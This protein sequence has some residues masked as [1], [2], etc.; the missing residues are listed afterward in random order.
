MRAKFRHI[1]TSKQRPPV[2]G[3]LLISLIRRRVLNQIWKNCVSRARHSTTCY[4]LVASPGSSMRY[5]QSTGFSI[6][7]T[8][9][10]PEAMPISANNRLSIRQFSLSRLT[11]SRIRSAK[12]WVRSIIFQTGL[13]SLKTQ[14]SRRTLPTVFS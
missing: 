4:F 1:K 5:T 6:R 8:R 12:H 2:S 10:S 14:R 3:I 13:H 11:R 9:R 7:A